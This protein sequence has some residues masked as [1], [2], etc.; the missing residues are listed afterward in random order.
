MLVLLMSCLLR[1]LAKYMNGER[2]MR[3]TNLVSESSVKLNLMSIIGD[4]GLASQQQKLGHELREFVTRTHAHYLQLCIGFHATVGVSES[5]SECLEHLLN[6]GVWFSGVF[7]QSDAQLLS[8]QTASAGYKVNSFHLVIIKTIC[9]GHKVS[10]DLSHPVLKLR[11]LA[12]SEE[13]RI[14]H[15]LRLA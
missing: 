3:L 5:G 2:R 7:S 14:R 9:I 6:T 11:L 15:L 10:L 4:S 12:I 8:C 1:S 13:R